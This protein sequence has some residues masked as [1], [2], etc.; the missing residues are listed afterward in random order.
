MFSF[1]KLSLL[2]LR[3]V[4]GYA[5]FAGALTILA[6]VETAVAQSEPQTPVP[7]FGPVDTAV[8][9]QNQ[10]ESA[11]QEVDDA[12][13]VNT[14][15]AAT[16]NPDDELD[17][18]LPVIDLVTALR[19]K[20]WLTPLHWGR[21]SLLSVNAYEGYNSNPQFQRIPFGATITSVSSLVLYS[22]AFAGWRANIQYEPFFWFSSKRTLSDFAA[23]SFDLRTIRHINGNWHWTLGDRLRYSP[24]HST[25]ESKGFVVDPSGGFS[26]GDAFLSSGRN[27]L[28]NGVIATLT[29]RYGENST[30]TF[31]A[32]QDYTRLS[33]F[34][35]GS[36]LID[37]L[38]SQE[39]FTFSAGVTWRNRISLK[40]TLNAEY[41]YRL[42]DSTGTS[43]ADVNSQAASIG[44][45]HKFTQ[46]LGAS[47]SAGPAWSL[48]SGHN[49][50]SD[51]GRT[52]LHGSLALSKEFR[53]GG[54][55]LSFARSDSFSGIISDSFHN[56]YDLNFHREF[57]TRFHGSISGSYIQ[58][59]FSNM[60]NTDGELVSGEL[61]YFLSRNWALFS[62][63]RY[64]NILGNERIL[65]PEKSV[66]LGFRWSWVPEKP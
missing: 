11:E 47:I 5:S 48:Y 8:P 51:H 53:R 24:T 56:R 13:Y 61:R 55:I 46:S 38:P 19:M 64:L 12:V 7:A 66:I 32:D 31:H 36:Q 41:T 16:P 65:G 25:E 28:V 52:T 1:L 34:V 21:L 26:I 60:R 30:L 2:V 29:D 33:S 3:V 54:A 27:V 20:T 14:E 42:L 17:Q 43:V 63:A 49:G 39:A 35:G 50:G 44:V 22:T 23:A 4:L 9:V 58:Q 6:L 62:Q 37:T 18:E 57:T 59:E 15:D 45:S 10:S 40:D